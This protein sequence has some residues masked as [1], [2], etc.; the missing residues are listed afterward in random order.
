MSHVGTIEKL[1]FPLAVAAGL[2]AK[3]RTC[4]GRASHRLRNLTARGPFPPKNV[5]FLNLWLANQSR[6]LS[7]AA[8]SATSS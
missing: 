5:V 3:R 8:G 1:A 4:T 7:P 6:T 2:S